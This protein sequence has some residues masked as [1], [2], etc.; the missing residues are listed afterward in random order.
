M[1]GEGAAT[2]DPSRVQAIGICMWLVRR[3]G[4]HKAGLGGRQGGPTGGS[5]V[6]AGHQGGGDPQNATGT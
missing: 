5:G 6:A 2:F 3:R 1:E 4:C